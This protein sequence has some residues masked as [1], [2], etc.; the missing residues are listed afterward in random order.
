MG[1]R[2]TA[3]ITVLCLLHTEDE[4][5]L[6]KRKKNDWK[7]FTLPG[8]HVESGESIV[9]AVIREMNEE[10]G[11]TVINPRLC[12]IKQFPIESGRYLVFLFEASEFTG[13]LR[14]SDE[15]EM[16]WIKKDE[17]DNVEL[18]ED[19]HDL[20]DV[21]MNNNLTEFQYVIE[22]GKWKVIKK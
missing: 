13:E 16:L 7:G 10:T 4:Y 17:L 19:F 9:D 5:L 2:E 12:G 3:E 15:G 14:S 21:M 8:G 1:R 6:Q 20:I 18:V 11:L 22:D